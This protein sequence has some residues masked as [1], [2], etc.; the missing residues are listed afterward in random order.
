MHDV[1]G[2]N[3]A[4]RKGATHVESVCLIFADCCFVAI[5]I[6]A[7]T[8]LPVLATHLQLH[9]SIV[10]ITEPAAKFAVDILQHEY[11]RVYVGLVERV[12]ISSGE[13]VQRGRA[14]RLNCG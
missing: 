5:S 13:F 9:H 4:K 11:V 2:C 8:P 12:E 1:A 10:R 14:L 7:W 6:A 3:L